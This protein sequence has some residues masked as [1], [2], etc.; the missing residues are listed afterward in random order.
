MKRKPIQQTILAALLFLA[1]LNA[2]SQENIKQNSQYIIKMYPPIMHANPQDQT[3]LN[4]F[5]YQA[6]GQ[7][8]SA[9]PVVFSTSNA[10]IK[11]SETTVLTD[12]AGRAAIEVTTN[13]GGWICGQIPQLSTPI[14][15]CPNTDNKNNENNILI[16]IPSPTILTFSPMIYTWTGKSTHKMRV[17]GADFINEIAVIVAD[18]P[19]KVL[20]V[21]SNLI[22]IEFSDPK[23]IGTAQ[24]TFVQV[25]NLSSQLQVKKSGVSFQMTK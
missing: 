14:Q 22:E 17:Y 5:A 16:E 8:V 2:N 24:F 1:Q 4:L 12:K 18:N 11:L 21:T 19:A 10:A 7:P 6:D 13:I 3:T 23:S 20:S 25:I 15:L 9:L